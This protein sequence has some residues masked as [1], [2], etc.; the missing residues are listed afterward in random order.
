MFRAI[1]LT[2]A[3]LSLSGCFGPRLSSFEKSRLEERT[4]DDLDSLLNDLG[5]VSGGI[6]EA[7]SAARSDWDACIGGY[8]G[9][10]RCYEA[11]G[12]AASGT[13]SMHLDGIPCTASLTIDDVRYEYTIEDRQWTGSW[14]LRDDAWYDIAWSGFQDA[15]LVIEGHDSWDGTYDSSFVMNAGT[16]VVDGDGNNDGWS[17]DYSYSG[18]LDR[19]WSVVASKDADGAV[20]GSVSSDDGITCT[21]SGQDYDYVL[22]CP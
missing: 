6:T 1:L 9:C 4:A 16:A 3:L 13:L 11:S 14:A 10:R 17:V 18:F 7:T 20:E 2:T 15:A 21:L 12:T 8:A 19:T 22:D 5:E